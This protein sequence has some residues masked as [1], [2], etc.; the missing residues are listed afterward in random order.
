MVAEKYM[1]LA[2]LESALFV[3]YCSIAAVDPFRL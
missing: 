2:R 1:H 3:R